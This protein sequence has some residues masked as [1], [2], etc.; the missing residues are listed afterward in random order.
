M[1]PDKTEHPLVRKGIEHFNAGRFEAAALGFEGALA[2]GDASVGT[3]CFLA[4]AYAAFG[5]TDRAVRH[6]RKSFPAKRMPPRVLSTLAEILERDGKHSQALEIY[7]RAVRAAPDSGDVRGKLG[8]L[9]LNLG[10]LPEARAHLEKAAS[11]E[12]RAPGILLSLA[13]CLLRQGRPGPAEKALRKALKLDKNMTEAHLLLGKTLAAQNRRDESVEAYVAA[14]RLS[15]DTE[16]KLKLLFQI[17]WASQED[18]RLDRMRDAFTEFLK[19]D[20]G[21]EE[22]FTLKRMLALTALGRYAEA[23]EYAER[24]LDRWDPTKEFEPLMEPWA[25]RWMVSCDAG[26]AAKQLD[27]LDALIRGKGASS[28]WP[29]IWRG[30]LLC[31]QQRYREALAHFDTLTDFP[32]RRYGWMRY[33]AGA[34][35]LRLGAHQEAA[36]D[37]RAALRAESR[38]WWT[39][40]HLAEVR[41]CSGN[42]KAAFREFD[43]AEK[44]SGKDLLARANV[45]CWRGEAY[46]WTGRYKR[47]LKDLDLAVEG[48]VTLAHCWRGAAR[49]LLGSPQDAL[50]DLDIALTADPLDREALT[51]RGEAKRRLGLWREALLDLDRAVELGAGTW[52]LVNRALVWAA[53]GENAKMWRD[54]ER[55]PREAAP[56]LRGAAHAVRQLESSLKSARG[57][58]RPESY[59]TPIFR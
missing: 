19:A 51:W 48:G 16:E 38:L 32:Q 47:A 4:H 7:E 26:W 6:L 53:L 23:C 27:A 10:R 57:V 36:E 50:L 49:M 22:A 20:K 12:K 58:R 39:R 56:L 14:A 29:R 59:L 31:H 5:R 40:C 18:G 42:A 30:V 52:A 17:G 1:K 45:R 13:K 33:L 28:P 55:V 44:A 34:W 37:L 8:I 43:A 25:G 54:F 15:P 2:D 24:Y 3:H 41:L 46:L 9:Y 35:R 11:L 21:F